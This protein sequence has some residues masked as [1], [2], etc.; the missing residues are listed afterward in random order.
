M[1]NWLLVKYINPSHIYIGYRD[2]VWHRQPSFQ[3]VIGC[4][5]VS[6]N[7]AAP[8]CLSHLSWPAE[9][10]HEK[11]ALQN[12]P[13]SGVLAHLKLSWAT[14]YICKYGFGQGCGMFMFN[15][16]WYILILYMIYIY[17]L[18]YITS[19]YSYD[20]YRYVMYPY[21]VYVCIYLHSLIIYCIYCFFNFQ[22]KS[23]QVLLFVTYIVIGLQL[24][25][26]CFFWTFHRLCKVY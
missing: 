16:R 18:W 20:I 15:L 13:I 2:T 6:Q 21:I 17:F 9:R 26:K 23:S 7:K 3:L 12:S 10:E 22:G 24:V 11:E 14:L 4:V 25:V 5:C 8:H 19:I 1:R